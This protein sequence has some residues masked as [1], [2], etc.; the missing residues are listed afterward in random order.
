MEVSNKKKLIGLSIF[1]AVIVLPATVFHYPIGILDALTLQ[2]LSDYGIQIPFWRVLFEPFLGFLLFLNQSFY[3]LDELKFVLLWL[4]VFFV[5]YSLAKTLSLSDRT[6]RRSFILRQL[7]NIPL[8]IG[9][10]FVLL[11]VVIF[12][13]LPNNTIVN[14]SPNAI[15][16]TTHTH[17]EF[18]HDGLISQE[19][20]WKWHKRNGFDAFFITDH[21]NHDKTLEFVAAQRNKQFPSE[22]LVMGGEEFSGTNHLSLLGLKKPFRTKGFTDSMAVAMTRADSGAVLVNHWFDGERKSLDYYKELGVDGFEIENTATDKR[23][24]REVYKRIGNFCATNGLLLNGGLDFHGYGSACTLWNALDIPGWR[25]LD[26]AAKEKA[27]L[28]IIRSRDQ[29]KIKVLLYNDRSYYSKDQLLFR[30]I[31]A[32]FNYFRTLNL[33]QGFSWLAWTLLFAFICQRI[34][35]KERIVRTLTVQRLLPLLGVMGALFLL[36][37]GWHYFNRIKP[38]ED[39]TEMYQE[40]STLLFYAGAAFLIYS[41]IVLLFRQNEAK[42]GR[43]SHS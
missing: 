31:L 24:D 32:I 27:I 40:Y 28:N 36:G 33:Y 25:A 7:I 9:L 34:S 39:F 13:P 35:N 30:P 15:L 11:V 1:L 37:L 3:T 5:V 17:T 29:S 14:N 22:P 42:K 10:W 21:N 12:I 26:P 18:S 2:P 41:V 4:V 6:L 20:L 38:V 16:V 8:L 19:G 43:S 23:Y